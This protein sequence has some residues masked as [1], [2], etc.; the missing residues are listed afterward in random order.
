MQGNDLKPAQ[1]ARRRRKRVGRGFT[2]GT[3]SGRGMNGQKS[4][5]GGTKGAGFEGGQTPW[6]RRLPKYRGFKSRNH[7]FYQI[8][9]L[10]DLDRFE[11][12]A[13]VDG[14]A[15]LEKGLVD[16]L[17]EPVKVLANGSLSKKLTVTVDAVSAS[18]REAIESAGGKVEVI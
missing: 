7:T 5:S 9:S 4:R 3:F 15:L 17:K 8:V 11:D 14:P 2:D 6:Y 1:G 16:N 13:T 12:G 18:A 10:N